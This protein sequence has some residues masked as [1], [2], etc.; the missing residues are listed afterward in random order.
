MP[1]TEMVLAITV[2][3]ALA[4]AFI[5][6][7][8]FFMTITLH[9]TIRKAIEKDPASAEGLLARIAAQPNEQGDDRTAIISIAVG[10]AMIVASVVIGNPGWIHYGIAAAVF[11][12]IVGTAL[13][14]Q[15]VR[16]QRA[17]GRAPGE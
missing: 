17:G 8:R 10:I 15:Q 2:C 9:R 6:L 11:P 7:L 16:K 1:A 12:L 13:W 14:L 3:A 5:H 4:L